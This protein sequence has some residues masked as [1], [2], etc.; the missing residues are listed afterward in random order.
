MV[1]PDRVVRKNA[2]AYLGLFA[3]GAA[4]LLV[5]PPDDGAY[6]VCP[7]LSLTGADCPL[8]GGMR[9]TTDLLHGDVVGAVDHNLLVALLLPISLLL[10]TLLV[11]RP[12]AIGLLRRIPRK[13]VWG[14]LVA[15]FGIFWAIRLMPVLPGLSSS[16][17]F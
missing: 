6:P 11:L 5:R 4:A 8:C 2:G 15:I 16:V 17:G 12:R 3:A 13:V 7:F 14:S 9:A 1:A 10:A